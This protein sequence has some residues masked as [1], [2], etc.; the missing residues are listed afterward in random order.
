MYIKYPIRRKYTA[1]PP[2]TESLQFAKQENLLNK[3]HPHLRFAKFQSADAYRSQPV[4]ERV[5]FA[6]F[7]SA[8]EKWLVSFKR[9][10]C[11]SQ[12]SNRRMHTAPSRFVSGFAKI[13]S[14]DAA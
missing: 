8:D 2:K 13:Q 12:S 4:R 14:A 9:D 7:Q 11:G 5:G 1:K 3:S 6:K 10:V